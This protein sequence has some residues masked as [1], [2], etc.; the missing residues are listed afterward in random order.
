[1]LNLELKKKK[2]NSRKG[3]S[4]RLWLSLAKKRGRAVFG[5]GTV[6]RGFICLF[7]EGL[8]CLFAFP[9]LSLCV[10]S[11]AHSYP[12]DCRAS[13][14]SVHRI[15]RAGILEWVA[16][17]SSRR[18]SWPRDWT[19]VSCLGRGILY[20]WATW[21]TYTVITSLL[22]LPVLPEQSTAQTG[23][24]KQIEVCCHNSGDS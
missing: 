19:R 14:S 2:W 22:S 7:I 1:M 17:S 18:S 11:I 12:V 15:L 5:A 4:T 3:I 23:W 20:H 16:I 24:L 6:S 21:E 9:A 10:C 13:D 8:G